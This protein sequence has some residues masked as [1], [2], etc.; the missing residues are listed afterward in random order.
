LDYCN[1]LTSCPLFFSEASTP[2]TPEAKATATEAL[3]EDELSK[4]QGRLAEAEELAEKRVAAVT[5]QLDA[6]RRS[7]EETKAKVTWQTMLV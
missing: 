3:Y 7:E 5:A 1:N 6:I 2:S 4:F